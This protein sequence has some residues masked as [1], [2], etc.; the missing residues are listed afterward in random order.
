MSQKRKKKANL[1]Q[2]F[3]IMTTE[4][5]IRKEMENVVSIA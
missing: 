4:T 1:E 2:K 5:N 3:F